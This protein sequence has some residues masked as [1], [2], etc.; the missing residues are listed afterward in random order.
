MNIPFK[1]KLAIFKKI[2]NR[3]EAFH[4]LT[5]EEKR[6]EIAF[7]GLNLVLAG[8]ITASYGS[9]WGYNLNNIY[10][11]DAL[12]FQKR[13]I[14]NLPQCDVCQRGLIMVSTIRLGNKLSTND[15]NIS[16]GDENNLQG[17]SLDSMY[18]M[19][20]EYERS[21]FSQ[22]Y[23]TNVGKKLINICCNV[24]ANGD[25]TPKDKVDYLELWNI[26]L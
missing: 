23:D 10:E 20:E 5:D 13:L 26:T 11:P 19:E 1:S 17:F 14:D 22:P 2:E 4:K 25:F 6:K 24:I 15:F 21:A 3:N 18:N 7:D 9:Y 8:K 12:K 16:D